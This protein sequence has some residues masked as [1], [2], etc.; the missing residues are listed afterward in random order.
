MPSKAVFNRRGLAGT[1]SGSATPDVE[2]RLGSED[3]WLLESGLGLHREGVPTTFGR[4]LEAQ[5]P[6]HAASSESSGGGTV[7]NQPQFGDLPV[8]PEAVLRRLYDLT[9]AEARLAQ[10]LASGDSL[11]EVATGLGIRM[12][13]A[14][15]QLGSI[16]AKTDTRRQAKLVALLCHLAHLTCYCL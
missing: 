5:L 12:S 14:R 8:P 9:P 3:R 10:G 7:V 6:A 2:R 11:D 13:T 16:F 4:G 15:T 1:R